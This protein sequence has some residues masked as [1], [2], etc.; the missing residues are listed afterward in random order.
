V[1]IANDRFARMKNH[2]TSIRQA[3]PNCSIAEF[4]KRKNQSVFKLLTIAA[5]SLGA[6]PN[7][8]SGE[9]I[10][11]D[12]IQ[13]TASLSSYRLLENGRALQQSSRLIWQRCSW[14]QHFENGQCLGQAQAVSYAD[15]QQIVAG[16]RRSS[17]LAWRIPSLPQLAGTVQLTC[18]HPAIDNSLFPNTMSANY[19]TSTEFIEGPG[20]HWL[21]NFDNG[22]NVVETNGDKAF[23]RLIYQR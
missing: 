15:A 1:I 5:F 21:V 2:L 23:L 22:G 13:T 9:Q 19:W 7:E 16:L 20:Q 3:K 17:G 12:N 8:V 6:M 18:F 10:C 4:T 11:R 14:G